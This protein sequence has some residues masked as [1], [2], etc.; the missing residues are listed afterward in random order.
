MMADQTA[1]TAAIGGVIGYLGA[2][3]SSASIFEGILWPQRFF[4]HAS[5]SSVLVTTLLSSAGGPLHRAAV[6]V[7]DQF[8]ER[9]IYR[10]RRQ[11]HMLGTVFFPERESDQYIWHTAPTLQGRTTKKDVRNGFWISVL[12]DLNPEK[13]VATTIS[14]EKSDVEQVGGTARVER[15]RHYLFWLELGVVESEF[16]VRNPVLSEARFTVTTALLLVLSEVPSITTALI[17]V[18]WT[19]DYPLAIILLLPVL[20][21]MITGLVSVRRETFSTQSDGKTS[22]SRTSSGASSDEDAKL[23]GENQIAG[24]LFQVDLPHLGLAFVTTDDANIWLQFCRHYGHPMRTSRLDR[25]REI[26]CIAIVYAFVLIFPAGLICLIWAD[27]RAQYL[28]LGYQIYAILAMHFSRLLGLQG[29]ARTERAVAR[30]LERSKEVFLKV[31]VENETV[32]AA[33]RTESF[34]SM[35]RL[36]ERVA[37]VSGNLER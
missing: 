3:I 9:G 4:N 16:S 24:Q 34:G 23:P 12:R 6:Q 17:I 31:G 33:V 32:R 36:R 7:L 20:L 29:A 18:C 2:E 14:H 8:R 26:L 27:V 11:G 10:G 19:S 1:T 13:L 25:L 30:E 35:Q 15:T 5:F 22:I 28:W 37:E 21:K